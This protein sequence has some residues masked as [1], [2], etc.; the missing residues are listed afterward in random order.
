[1]SYAI[2]AVDP[3]IGLTLAEALEP[4]W[5]PGNRQH[6]AMGWLEPLQNVFSAASTIA[7]STSAARCPTTKSAS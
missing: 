7:T 6:E 2:D 4:F 5:I 3:A 1:L